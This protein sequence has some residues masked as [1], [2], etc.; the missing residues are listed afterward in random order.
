MSVA[1]AMPRSWAHRNDTTT[2]APSAHA[3]PCA[4]SPPPHLHARLHTPAHTR[5]SHDTHDGRVQVVPD[6]QFYVMHADVAAKALGGCCG[7]C[8]CCEGGGRFGERKHGA[9]W[10]DRSLVPK[11]QMDKC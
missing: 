11:R 6:D 9:Y 8:S 2:R 1:V 7:E 10:K 4:H 3:V 5:H